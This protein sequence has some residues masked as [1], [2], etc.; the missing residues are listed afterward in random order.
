MIYKF[1]VEKL[2]YTQLFLE[3]NLISFDRG[4]IEQYFLSTKS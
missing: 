2:S 4:K 1:S 3:V